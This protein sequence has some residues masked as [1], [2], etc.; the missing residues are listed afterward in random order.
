MFSRKIAC[1]SRKDDW[2]N[3]AILNQV[4]SGTNVDGANVSFVWNPNWNR[5]LLLFARMCAK[6]IKNLTEANFPRADCRITVS[7]TV[8][9]FGLLF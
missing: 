9:N 8:V 3:C 1:S 7:S 6:G 5:D 4:S 2:W